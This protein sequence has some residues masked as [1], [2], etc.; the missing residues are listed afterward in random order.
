MPPPYLVDIDGHPHPL[1]G[2]SGILELI[3]PPSHLNVSKNKEQA[4]VLVD[5]DEFMK[6]RQV[7]LASDNKQL[8]KGGVNCLLK[9]VENNHV[10]QNITGTLYDDQPCCSSSAS[11]QVF[12]QSQDSNITME[13]DQKD[14]NILVS[15]CKTEEVNSHSDNSAYNKSLSNGDTN[16]VQ[17]EKNGLKSDDAIHNGHSVVTS[18]QHMTSLDHQSVK[19]A[20]QGVDFDQKGQLNSQAVVNDETMV[21]G[22]ADFVDSQKHQVSDQTVV[23]NQAAVNDQTAINDHAAVNDQAAANAVPSDQATVSNQAEVNNQA[24]VNNQTVVNNQ[25]VVNDQAAINNQPAV[26]DQQANNNDE[27]NILEFDNSEESGI[28]NNNNILSS[29]VWS[30]GLSDQEAKNA[31]SMWLSRTVIPHLDTEVYG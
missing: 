21:N 8:T 23:N 20:D 18:E 27:I 10:P 14:N 5:Y 2:Q 7:Q 29:I 13:T 28:D 22:S 25:A 11:N 30:C 12:S 6:Q 17:T 24:V 4:D 31:V 26:N 3:R 9:T 15:N 1:K 16:S 19:N